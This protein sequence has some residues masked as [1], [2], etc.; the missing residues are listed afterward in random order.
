MVYGKSWSRLSLSAWAPGH[1]EN[2]YLGLGEGNFPRGAYRTLYGAMAHGG[3]ADLQ[4]RCQVHSIEAHRGGVTVQASTDGRK[5][6]FHGSHVVC[7]VPLGVLKR[8]G[9]RIADL[10]PAKVNAIR[11][12]GFGNIEKV[13]MVFA[14]AFWHD[15]TH[16]HLLHYSKADDLA[17]PWWIDLQRTHGIPALMAFN[18]GP[19]ARGLHNISARQRVEL[20][21]SKL[22]TIV[23]HK[24]PKPI[25]WRATDW[26]GDRFTAGSYTA[27][28]VGRTV[29]DLDVIATPMKGRILFAGESTNR[30]RHSTADGAMSSGIREAKRL[31][32]KPAVELR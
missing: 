8:G 30:A 29:A 17:F 10:P 12:T 2:K 19:Y 18:G 25:A 22:S 9:V 31:L 3:E 26:R 4:L 1:S 28:L 15:L 11:H 32:R 24:V 5:R 7:A 23:G 16:T 21:L 20:A 13:V 27:M 6:T 14:D